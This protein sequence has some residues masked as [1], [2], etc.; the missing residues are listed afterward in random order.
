MW[1]GSPDPPPDP[2]RAPGSIVGP[3]V[4][5]ERGRPPHA[6]IVTVLC[7]PQR[8]LIAAGG[9][10]LFLMARLAGGAALCRGG[11]AERSRASGKPGRSL[12]TPTRM[13]RIIRTAVGRTGASSCSSTP[14]N[15]SGSVGSPAVARASILGSLDLTPEVG[16]NRVRGERLRKDRA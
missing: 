5:R 3:G 14:A 9:R 11:I 15:N 13:V 6:L 10:V 8:Q 4:R 12:P 16:F 1:G 7:E 2:R